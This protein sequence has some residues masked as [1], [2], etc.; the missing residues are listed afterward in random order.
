MRAIQIA[1]TGGPEVMAL[2]DLPT[3][4]P[5]SGQALVRVEAC[6]VNFIDV[7]QREGRYPVQLPF[8]PG[9]EAAGTV[10]SLGPAEPG[11]ARFGFKVGDRVAWANVLGSYAE[12]AVVPLSRL[13]AVPEGVTA[14]Q[15][16]G[17]MLQGMTAHYLAHA[18]YPIQ[19][20]DTVLIHA[21]AGGVGLLLTQMAKRLG[22]RVFSTVSTD[23]KA[24]LARQAGADETILY[25][26]EDF[27]ARV[28][29][30]TGGRGLPVVYDSV[31][32]TTF[33][34]SLACLRPRGMLVLFG[35]SSGAVPPFDLIRLST[36]GSLY[37]TRPTLK[38]YTATREELEQRA[39]DVL[40]W[41]ADGTLKLRLEHTYP[42]A[43]AAEAH[44]DLEARK[45][46]GK[47]LLIP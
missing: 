46:T 12:F 6:G 34:G 1:H 27:T 18:T 29:E 33:D 22:A 7:Y 38:N 36:M 30:L 37:V 42:L 15:A 40:R 17:A 41:V 2:R 47:V 26:R 9:Q 25:T 23:E 21:G 3:P 20:D 14:R 39:G 31:G 10:A 35:G 19:P 43:D 28:R 4:E 8:I 44:R 16:A 13:I 24:A 11:A 45:T 5:G 32:K